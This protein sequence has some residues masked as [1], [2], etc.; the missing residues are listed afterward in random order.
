VENRKVL[1]VS[2]IAKCVKLAYFASNM[3]MLNHNG[4]LTII[5]LYIYLQYLIRFLFVNFVCEVYWKVLKL[6]R[7]LGVIHL[8]ASHLCFP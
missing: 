3:R 4:V 2:K 7:L 6:S 1:S 5:E 8:P